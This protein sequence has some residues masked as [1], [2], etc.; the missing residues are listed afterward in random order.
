MRLFLA[1]QDLGNYAN[2]LQELVGEKRRALVVSNARD[3][4]NDE[5]R[6]ASSVEKTLL[7]LSKIGIAAKRLDL[8]SYFNKQSEL[9][10]LIEQEEIGLIFSIGGNVFCLSTAMHASGLDEIIRKGLAE[11]EFVYGGYS[12]G[13]MVASDNLSRYQY[14]VE[15]SEKQPLHS[16]PN[17]THEVYRLAPYKRGLGL[18]S[19]QYIIPHM[20][21]SEHAGASQKRIAKIE[22]AGEEAIRLNDSDVFV[23]NGN[24]AHIMRG[25]GMKIY[26]ARH[27][28]T[29]WNVQ[30]RAQ[31]RTDIPLNETGIG[32][33]RVL[34]DNIKNIQFTAVYSSP[35][36]RAAKTAHTATDDKYNIIYDERLIE[37]SFGD[38]EGKEINNWTEAT[39]YNIG[40]LKLNT[41]IGNIEPV[42]EVLARTK[43]FLDDIKNKHSDTDTILIVTHGQASRGLHHNI[44]GYNDDTD[45]WSVEYGNAEAREYKI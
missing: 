41:N 31:G 23:I 20:D 40:G 21:N 25:G 1:S 9:K 6:A 34:R 36:K 26:I 5:E 37:R 44:V 32:Q 3:Y 18:L 13:T 10:D 12:A 2:V 30:H 24:S 38:F 16:I 14:E 45:W 4:Y 43:S 15:A 35:L 11:D 33:A 19:Q 22:Q 39:G 29:D 28:Q 42:R 7:N 27:G 8:K 17:I